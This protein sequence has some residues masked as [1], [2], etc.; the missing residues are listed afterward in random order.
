MLAICEIVKYSHGV[1]NINRDKLAF[2]ETKESVETIG[3]G[4]YFLLQ[5]NAKPFK[6]NCDSLDLFPK[7]ADGPC[8][9]VGHLGEYYYLDE[10]GKD[11]S[12]PVVAFL[13]QKWNRY[14]HRESEQRVVI[15]TGLGY[16]THPEHEGRQPSEYLVGPQIGTYNKKTNI[17]TS[18]NDSQEIIEPNHFSIACIVGNP[19]GKVISAN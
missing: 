16:G 12:L 5:G 10:T 8:A 1:V 17:L 11:I 7:S 14:G 2:D 19:Y 9:G 18:L 4:E 6:F 15:M 13:Y 3:S